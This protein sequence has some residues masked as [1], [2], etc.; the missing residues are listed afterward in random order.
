MKFVD[1]FKP[2][3][4]HSDPRIRSEAIREMEAEY[5]LEDLVSIVIS[6]ELLENQK[7]ALKKIDEEDALLKILEN[8]KEKSIRESA[9]IKLND[10]RVKNI[11]RAGSASSAFQIL[12]SISDSKCLEDIALG[13][14][15]PEIKQR[16]LD[17]IHSTASFFKIAMKES[18]QEIALKAL[19][20]VNKPVHLETLSRKAQCKAVR[21]AA[22]ERE[23]Q[24]SADQGSVSEEQVISAKFELLCATME[25][26]HHPDNWQEA[27]TKAL[28]AE[29]AWKILLN[30]ENYPGNELLSRFQR[31]KETFWD[32]HNQHREREN[33]RIREEKELQENL[34]A[35]QEVCDEIDLLLNNKN[36]EERN[37]KIS[38]VIENWKSIG[39]TRDEEE[40]QLN[41]RFQRL[42]DTFRKEKEEVDRA[43]AEEE[44]RL[45]NAKSREEKIKDIY[46][47]AESL[48]NSQE[49]KETQ[50]ELKALKM[51]WEK[52]KC[53]EGH[54]LYNKFIELLPRIEK[55]AVEQDKKQLEDQKSNLQKMQE[56]LPKIES[57]VDN[58][59][60]ISA[61]RESRELMNSWRELDNFEIRSPE[62]QQ[63]YHSLKSKYE[64]SC[65]RFKE[66]QE[67]LRWSNLKKK[68]DICAQLKKALDEEMES[69]QL[70]KKLRELQNEWKSIGPVS[71]DSSKEVWDEYRRITDD[72]Y[73]KC[74]DY[75]SELEAE[76]K[77]NLVMK[78]ELCELAEKQI[79][80]KNW[81]EASEIIR[82][83]QA[84]WK[85]IGPVPKEN[86]DAVWEKF[87]NTCDAFFSARRSYF[88]D[89]EKDKEENLKKKEK[90][91]ELVESHKES[92]DWKETADIF[93]KAQE[94]WKNIGPVPKEKMEELWDRFRKTCDYF[95]N[96]REAYF[97]QREADK[98]GNFK[99]KEEL[100]IQV[101]NLDNLQSDVDKFNL[102]KKLQ[103][104]WKEIG[105]VDR[106]KAEALWERFR[107]PIDAYFEQRKDR[108]E[109]EQ[110]MRE[111]NLKKKEE[112]CEQAVALADSTEWKETSEKLKALQAAWKQIGPAPRERDKEVWIQFRKAC[113]GFF[114]RMKDHY[115]QLDD[116]RE[117]NLRTKEDLCFQAEVLA[118]FEKIQEQ[119]GDEI[120][121]E[122]NWQ[123]AS[124]KI[125]ELQRKWKQTGPVPKNRSDELWH[126]FR[127]ACDYVFDFIRSVE[128]GELPDFEANLKVK[129][130]LCEDAE[131]ISQQVHTDAQIQKIKELQKEWKQIGPV[132]REEH[133]EIWARFKKACDIVFAEDERLRE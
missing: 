131:R 26:L 133:E 68:Q 98:E 47:R 80:S 50:K 92:E 12:E 46:N 73:E 111:E 37:K 117:L 11:S 78:E 38:E 30:E 76:R 53:E 4:K 72:I 48:L 125:K 97:K 61:E 123:E 107:K 6:D 106:R 54:P 42:C 18:Q 59:D 74:Q 115:R 90:L 2:R 64:A 85:D 44:I 128:S 112:L 114:N 130:E 23:K 3:W 19:E 8:T 21:L 56:L 70:F 93:K 14:N 24:N 129:L 108:F 89:L 9:Q 99:K 39:K 71:W 118:G 91:C 79:E 22:R 51:E 60:L 132:P 58:P 20:K 49:S 5:H 65:D 109:A 119:E 31:A 29:E 66:A 96:R 113:D 126:R 62:L 40:E 41:L 94:D 102:I 81:K 10:I 87:R 100:C 32:L 67:W 27:H 1:F 7:L 43:R 28:E 122:K 25:S 105:S 127:R 35:K 52:V 86:S 110:K 82:N 124:Q 75:F 36:T 57:L 104:E 69:K 34:T 55:A 95:F 17:K 33:Q 103:A 88:E 120:A 101:E 121:G 16:C 84:K 15:N 83:A 13:N 116:Q 63:E 45:R 77:A